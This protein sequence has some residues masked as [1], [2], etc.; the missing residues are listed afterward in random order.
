MILPNSNLEFCYLDWESRMKTSKNI[1]GTRRYARLNLLA[2]ILFIIV[3]LSTYAEEMNGSLSLDFAIEQAQRNDPWLAENRHVQAALESNA[4]AAGTLPDPRVSLGIA[5]IGA[6]NLDFN[7]E[8]MTQLKAG[9]SQMFPRGDTLHLQTKKLQLLSGQNP[10]LRD[11]RKK[12]IAVT[13]AKLW[14]D[15]YKAKESISLIDNDRELFEQLVEIS[16]A[17]YSSAYGS[18]QQQDVIRAQLELTRLD[19]RLTKLRQQQEVSQKR[20]RQWVSGQF[21]EQYSDFYAT[22]TTS[23]FYDIDSRFLP[24]LNLI[25]PEL[26]I[27]E[28]SQLPDVLTS[29]LLNHPSVFALESRINASNAEI[30]LTKQKYKPQWGIN[31]EYGYRGNDDSGTNRADLFSL[32]ISFDLPIFTENRQ[33]K[34]VQAAVSEAES[35]KIQ[36][37]MLLRRMI[38]EFETA[39]VQLQR[40]NQR[41][42]L[43]QQQ[44]LPQIHDQAEASLTAYTND[45]GDF[46]EVV[47]ARIDV[48]DAEIDKLEIDV[49]RQK[50]IAQLNYFLVPEEDTHIS[51]TEKRA[52]QP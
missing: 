23:D 12:Q 25:Y 2:S 34:Q 44:L 36:K 16:E 20:L 13:V 22:N 31:A 49:D 17:S 8:D 24:E 1:T 26:L 35:V 7:Q 45:E 18:T 42:Q 21:V 52:G 28:D 47:R 32:G 30:E 39:K 46:S 27:V 11:A 43:Y 29:Y 33:D 41:Y 37:W 6:D 4:I 3:S 14:F 38:A 50:T 48:L 40:L 9:I 15:V 5:N 19:D 51:D 10:H